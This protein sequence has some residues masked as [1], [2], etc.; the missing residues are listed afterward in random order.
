[1]AFYVL[2]GP[3]DCGNVFGYFKKGLVKAGQF[4]VV[5]DDHY[6]NGGRC[7]SLAPGTSQN[8]YNNKRG[9]KE[10]ARARNFDRVSLRLL[11]FRGSLDK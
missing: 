10:N 3:A 9:A 7:P 6:A 5:E 1:M 8:L 4:A 2:E 11:A